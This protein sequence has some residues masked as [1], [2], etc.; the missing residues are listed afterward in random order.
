MSADDAMT[1]ALV[2]SHSW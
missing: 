2:S 1:Q